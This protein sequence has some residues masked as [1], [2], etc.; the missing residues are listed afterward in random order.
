MTVTVGSPNSFCTVKEADQSLAGATV[1]VSYNPTTAEENGTNDGVLVP[2]DGESE[3]V[4]VTNTYSAVP[5]EQAPQVAA[6]QAVQ[7]TP[8]FTG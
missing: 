3:L 5:V 4:T 8:A 7:T 1:V 6:A 2:G